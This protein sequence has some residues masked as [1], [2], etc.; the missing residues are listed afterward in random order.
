MSHGKPGGDWKWRVALEK[1]GQYEEILVKQLQISVP[2]FLREDEMPLVGRKYH[3]AGYGEFR[4]KG[5]TGI[6]DPEK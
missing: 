2:S 3:I 6:V 1:R 5:G 4:A